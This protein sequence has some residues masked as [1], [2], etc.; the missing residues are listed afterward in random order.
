MKTASVSDIKQ[1]LINTPQ[2]QLMELCLQLVKY[3][4]E[5]K[6]LLSYLLFESYDEKGYIEKVKGGILEQFETI[7]KTNLYLAKK[8]LRKILRIAAKHIKYTGSK[9]AEAEL[10]IYFCITLK[11]SGVYIHKSNALTN[12]YNQQLKKINKVIETMHED[13]QYDYLKELEKL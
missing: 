10:L 9:Q 3:K 7:N 4:K 12:L 13:L 8:S 2:K 1:E 11:R 6:E 5:N